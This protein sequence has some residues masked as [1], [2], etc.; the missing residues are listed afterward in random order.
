MRVDAF[1]IHEP[2][3]ELHNTCVIAVLRPWI[4]V[5]R[6]GTQI[7][8][9][10]KRHLDAK[11]FGRLARPGNFYDFTR[12]RPR[13]N[14]VNG[15]RVLN[16]PNTIVDY[17]HDDEG[18]R[19]YLFLEMREPHA[20]GEDYTDALVTLLKRFEV[21]E[22]CGIGGMYDSVPH[23]RPLL[24]TGNLTK[25]QEER[26]KGLVSTQRSTYQG[27]TSIVNRVSQAQA[28]SEVMTTSLMVRLPQ[29]L[30]LDEDYMGAAHLMEVLCALYGFPG[31]LV[32][33][34]GGEKQYQEISRTVEANKP[35]IKELI[36]ELEKYYDQGI[37]ST[38]SQEQDDVSLS[39]DV[40]NFL[41]EMG[42][43]LDEGKDK[44]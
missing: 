39:P 21:T 25:D 27:P 41:D 30:Q 26:A 3:P 15:R 22:Y 1:E 43:R 16:I 18:S 7:L 19:D 32:D 24:V 40:A 5:G 34:A 14:T 8:T 6:V 13:T 44:Q 10:L 12:Y 20:N 4:N 35:E 42:E 37:A 9:K 29:Y 33:S 38:Q 31:S 28:D 23:T 11:E 2:I 17:A 36:E